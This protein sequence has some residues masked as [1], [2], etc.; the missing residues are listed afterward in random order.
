MSE[1]IFFF[2]KELCLEINTLFFNSLHHVSSKHVPILYN[3]SLN[4]IINRGRHCQL[5][6]GP[7]GSG[8]VKG[9]H[10]NILYKRFN[11]T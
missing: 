7:A 5:V 11:I 6:M 1:P 10:K 8:K 9:K 2:L 3:Q 4:I